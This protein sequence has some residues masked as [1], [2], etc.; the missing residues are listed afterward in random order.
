M[1]KSSPLSISISADEIRK[2]GS[3][4]FF[5]DSSLQ[6]PAVGVKS[7]SKSTRVYWPLNRGLFN[8]S[9]SFTY[10]VGIGPVYILFFNFES[11]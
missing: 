2:F 9:S 4:Q 7:S 3:R 1:V 6:E 8:R 5:Q 10:I 11:K